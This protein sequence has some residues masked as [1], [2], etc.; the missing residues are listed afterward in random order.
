MRRTPPPPKPKPK[1]PPQ[2]R[3]VRSVVIVCLTFPHPLG[4]S[5]IGPFLVFSYSSPPRNVAPSACIGWD[6]SRRFCGNACW[7]CVPPERP[8]R[9]GN[10]NRQL[11][12][13]CPLAC[14]ETQQP[15]KFPTGPVLVPVGQASKLGDRLCRRIYVR[16]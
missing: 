3:I 12:K 6:C 7:T 16:K 9:C 15:R 13:W 2:Q 8:A 4:S 14:S 1:P 11:H 10:V 5:P